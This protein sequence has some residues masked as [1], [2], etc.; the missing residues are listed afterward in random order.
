MSII[1]AMF[2]NQIDQYYIRHWYTALNGESNIGS[3]TDSPSWLWILNQNVTH[4]WTSLIHFGQLFWTILTPLVGQK[5]IL[6]LLGWFVKGI[7]GSVH[8]VQNTSHGWL[9]VC[10]LVFCE[11]PGKRLCAFLRWWSR[12]RHILTILRFWS[13]PFPPTIIRDI[14]DIN[15][16]NS[17]SMFQGFSSNYADCQN[18]WQLNICLHLSFALPSPN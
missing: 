16:L 18:L 7:K 14:T 1:F 5:S 11:K 2:T 12:G 9:C 13:L 4:G 6:E 17:V 10:V 15:K 3:L 8:C